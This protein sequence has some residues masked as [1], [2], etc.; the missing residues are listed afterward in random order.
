MLIITN[1]QLDF[2]SSRS[3]FSSWTRT[4]RKYSKIVIR[5]QEE[6]GNEWKNFRKRWKI[7]KYPLI[8]QFLRQ[9]SV[10]SKRSDFLSEN[11]FLCFDFL[12]CWVFFFSSTQSMRGMLWLILWFASNCQPKTS[13]DYWPI[14]YTWIKISFMDFQSMANEQGTLHAEIVLLSIVKE[15]PFV[16]LA[17]V[18]SKC[19]VSSQSSAHTATCLLLQT[20]DSDIGGLCALLQRVVSCKDA[21]IGATRYSYYGKSASR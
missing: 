11:A 13:E 15:V 8:L 17:T 7:D 1:G 12:I 3:V 5:Q 19:C 21:V 2:I 6:L 14:R 18:A 20:S 10:W 9:L 4:V 16:F